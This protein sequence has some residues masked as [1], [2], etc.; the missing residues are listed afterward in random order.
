[1]EFGYPIETACKLLRAARSAL[2][3]VVIRQ[4]QSQNR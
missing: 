2:P 3:Q 1:M 4:D